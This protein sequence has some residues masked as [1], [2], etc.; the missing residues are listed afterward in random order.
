MRAGSRGMP[1]GLLKEE[2]PGDTAGD[3]LIVREIPDE[4]WVR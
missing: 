1:A 4:E 3:F 2:V